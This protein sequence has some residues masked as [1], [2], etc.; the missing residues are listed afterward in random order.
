MP[1]SIPIADMP[2]RGRAPDLVDPFGRTITYLRLS[3]TDRCDL[4]CRYCMAEDMTFLPKKDVLSLEELLTVSDAFMDR[5]VRRIRLTGGEPLVRRNIQWL[6]DR[7][8]AR[9]QSGA[10]DEVTLT[11]NA[12]QLPAMAG[13]LARAGVR[14]INVSLDTLDPA[15]FHAITRRNRLDDVRRGLDA[16]EDAGLK[17]KLNAVV[18]KNRNAHTIP[19]LF[20]FARHRG[21]DLT[22]IETMP[23]GDVADARE[24]TYMPVSALLPALEARAALTPSDHR[25]GGPARY[26][27]IAGSR[28][29]LGLITPL[30]RNFCSGC[31]RVRVTCTGQIYM[32]LGQDDHVDLRAA[33]RGPDG[34][35]ALDAALD[36]AIGAK[37]EGH[38][39]AVTDGHMTGKVD[40][41]M[42]MTG[43]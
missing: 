35:A 31:N 14:R 21:F 20:D 19:D 8:G 37:P 7:L 33:L 39:F 17:V 36:R 30:S 6:I 2:A 23:M 18:M 3:V 24:D 26:M 34:A 27:D 41:H 32:C 42:S 38:D 28:S 16:A 4:R 13:K 1:D 43:G 29:R 12:T 11:T 10:L 15:T 25:T 40:R 5:G 9:V 22:L